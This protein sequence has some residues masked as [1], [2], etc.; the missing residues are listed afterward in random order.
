MH[1]AD[2]NHD[3]IIEAN[4]VTLDTASTFLGSSIPT[5]EASAATHVALW[6]GAISVGALFDYRGGYVVYNTTA[7][8]AALSGALREQY[9]PHAPLFLQ[10]RAIAF[11]GSG[12]YED[13]SFVRFRELSI[14]YAAP[15]GLV[16]AAHVASLTLTAAVRNL[17]LWTRYTGG[18]PEVSAPG[19]G[20]SSG[21]GSL[22]TTFVNND[23]RASDG[24]AV[25][26]AR[27]WVLRLNV[28]L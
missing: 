25:P 15:S 28:G 21:I 27:Y 2:L 8:D 3:G 7:E 16:R 18:D 5:R 12:M 13:G 17:A 11:N 23:A 9:D 4:E 14:T 26:L 6:H 20:G 19:G 24:S 22:G 10:A 1:F